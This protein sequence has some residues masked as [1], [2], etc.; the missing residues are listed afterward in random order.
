MPLWRKKDER[1]KGERM[2]GKWAGG[3]EDWLRTGDERQR[4]GER[5]E[6]MSERE[7]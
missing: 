5:K 4:R 3:G 6:A 2:E 7:R 1:N